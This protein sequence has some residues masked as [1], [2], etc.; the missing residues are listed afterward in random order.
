MLILSLIM[1][2]SGGTIIDIIIVPGDEDTA[3]EDNDDGWY[4]D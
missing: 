2:S 1:N 4:G 3:R